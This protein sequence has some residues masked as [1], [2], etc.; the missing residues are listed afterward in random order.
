MRGL[1]VGAA[2]SGL[3]VTRIA[4]LFN[5]PDSTVRGTICLDSVRNDGQ[6]RARTGRPKMYNDRDVRNLIRHVQLHPTDTYAQIR[7]ALNTPY[8]ARTIKGILKANGIMHRR[9]SKTQKQDM[10]KT[11]PD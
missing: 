3:S 11:T 5:V 8:S 2:G 6:S 10:Q 7:E 4:E 9:I 1:I